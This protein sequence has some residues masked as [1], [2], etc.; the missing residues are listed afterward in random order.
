MPS[1]TC[2][3]QPTTKTGQ[4][5]ATDLPDSS[6]SRRLGCTLGINGG[7]R[8]AACRC[9]LSNCACVD[10]QQTVQYFLSPGFINRVSRHMGFRMCPNAFT[11]QQGRLEQAVRLTLA[12]LVLKAPGVF[13]KRPLFWHHF[14]GNFLLQLYR[15]ETKSGG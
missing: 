10:H 7:R 2:L 5:R 14:G 15:L 12:M 1:S 3:H 9:R 11:S 4:A 13:G 6:T 8:V